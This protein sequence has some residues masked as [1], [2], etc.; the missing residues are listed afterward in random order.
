MSSA[1]QSDRPGRLARA[2]RAVRHAVFDES[3][4]GRAAEIAAWSNGASAVAVAGALTAASWERLPV[5]GAWVGLMGGALALV[6]LRLALTH[7]A[8]VWL[9]AA[10][11]TLSVAMLGGG[12]AWLFGHVVELAAA[13]SIA[14]VAGALL[15]ALAPAWSYAKIARRRAE[16]VRDSL[17]DP[18]SAPR[19]R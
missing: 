4:G 15:A 16:D 7:R 5:H 14:A 12:L 3:R 17:L 9:A 2:A 6:L 11:G 10:F 19:S 18:I 1:P 13:P 8:T